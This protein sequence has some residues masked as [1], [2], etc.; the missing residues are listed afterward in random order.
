MVASADPLFDL[1]LFLY[2]PQ[3]GKVTHFIRGLFF[4]RQDVPLL[5]GNLTVSAER[6]D[7]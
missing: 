6:E 5:I 3:K 7:Q 4:L 2:F 1:E